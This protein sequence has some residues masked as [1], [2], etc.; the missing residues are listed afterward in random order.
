METVKEQEID[1]EMVSPS[2]VNTQQKARKSPSLFERLT[3]RGRAYEERDVEEARA[4][5]AQKVERIKDNDDDLD[6]PAF[7]RR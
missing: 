6:I 1:I 3:G 5:H 2:S 4:V 7:L